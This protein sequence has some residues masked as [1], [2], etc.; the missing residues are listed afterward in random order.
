MPLD[1]AGLRVLQRE[2]FGLIVL[3]TRN[4]AAG[5]YAE[6]LRQL[7]RGPDPA[8]RL[9]LETPDRVAYALGAVPPMF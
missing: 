3:H 9:L 1:A 2:G 7:A 4:L 6:N 8:L 5:P